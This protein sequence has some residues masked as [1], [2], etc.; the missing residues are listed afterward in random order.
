MVPKPIRVHNDAGR[1][2]FWCCVLHGGIQL[3]H[4]LPELP[5]SV[6]THQLFP[7]VVSSCM[8]RFLILLLSVALL[9]G[10]S[11]SLSA[12]ERTVLLYYANESAPQGE[13]AELFEQLIAWSTQM[14]TTESLATAD[15]LHRD[16]TIFQRAID[17]DMDAIERCSRQSLQDLSVAILTNRLAR[18]GQWRIM[19]KD[20]AIFSTEPFSVPEYQFPAATFNPCSRGETFVAFLKAAV[21]AFPAD[22]TNFVLIVKSHGSEDRFLQPRLTFPPGSLNYE[23]FE[24]LYAAPPD[25]QAYYERLD[26]CS[27]TK[28]Q[29]Q[30]LIRQVGDD[31]GMHFS[32][33]GI[34]CCSAV[35]AETQEAG[36]PENIDVLM[37]IN[38][39]P[40]FLNLIYDEII[41]AF[42]SEMPLHE[43]IIQHARA[44]A[45]FLGRNNIQP[46]RP[47]WQNPL[48]VGIPVVVFIIVVLLRKASTIKSNGVSSVN[49]LDNPETSREPDL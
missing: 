41:P 24:Q 38:K 31:Y 19:R 25:E 46:S 27:V 35:T 16:R 6:A 39:N 2:R 8:K 32:L 33:V 7:S 18:N 10:A 26:Q 34:E 29:F 49:R 11:H 30:Q 20:A 36:L 4:V 14:G 1:E 43:S 5:Q 42:N 40:G 17:V 12:S 23:S 44:S 47:W 3:P 28:R 37:L 21:D 22:G 13:E 15:A 48:M 45:V 9:A